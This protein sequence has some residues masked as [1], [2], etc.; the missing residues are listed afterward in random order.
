MCS[1]I[2]FYRTSCLWMSSEACPTSLT[3]PTTCL[4]WVTITGCMSSV[5]DNFLKHYIHWILCVALWWC[6]GSH[7]RAPISRK[8]IT[9]ALMFLGTLSNV[10]H[11]C[12]LL[13]GVRKVG[14]CANSKSS[15]ARYQLIHFDLRRQNSTAYTFDCSNKHSSSIFRAK[16]WVKIA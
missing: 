8:F 10:W 11:W 1:G 4:W 16:Q 6:H 5:S 12:A 14:W 7:L 13:P 9:T 15:S 3:M 2:F